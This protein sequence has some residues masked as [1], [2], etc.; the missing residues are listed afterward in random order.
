MRHRNQT[1]GYGRPLGPKNQPKTTARAEQ[2]LSRSRGGVVA[3]LPMK[4]PARR[5]W[6]EAASP[7]ICTCNECGRVIVPNE[8]HFADQVSG[9]LVRHVECHQRAE[10]NDSKA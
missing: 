2:L 4:P 7:Y 10:A 1:T 9:H 3:P 6:R 8:Q 5:D